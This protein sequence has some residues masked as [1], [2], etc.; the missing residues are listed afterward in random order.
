M[1]T[2]ILL[3]NKDKEQKEFFKTNIIFFQSSMNLLK[4]FN[5]KVEVD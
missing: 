5:F 4:I 1:I 3:I 2:I